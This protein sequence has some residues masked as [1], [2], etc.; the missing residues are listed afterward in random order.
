MRIRNEVERDK[1]LDEVDKLFDARFDF[2]TPR[3]RKL[4][5]LVEALIRFDEFHYLPSKRTKLQSLFAWLRWILGIN[6]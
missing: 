6:T 4:L 1:V 5:Y 2:D 3:G